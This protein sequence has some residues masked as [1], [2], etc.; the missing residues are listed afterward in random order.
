[1]SNLTFGAV[2]YQAFFQNIHQYRLR[3]THKTLH[4]NY[5]QNKS[6]QAHHHIISRFPKT[7]TSRVEAR[8][9]KM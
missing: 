7:F 8:K 2:L 6:H 5:H 1:M 3:S 4:S 9:I